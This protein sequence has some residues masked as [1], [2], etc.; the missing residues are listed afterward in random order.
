MN[1]LAPIFPSCLNRPSLKNF[2]SIEDLQATANIFPEYHFSQVLEKSS[3]KNP[4]QY[5]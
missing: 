5:V 4:P 1:T 3:S 2:R